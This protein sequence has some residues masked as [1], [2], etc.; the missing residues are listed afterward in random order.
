[1]PSTPTRKPAAVRTQP[2][3]GIVSASHWGVFRG[4]VE[5]G[6]VVA[7]NPFERDSFP[8]P[9][10]PGI[11]DVAHSPTRIRAPVVRAGY[12]EHG[13]G[14]DRSRR[15]A[16][17]FVRVSWDEALDLVTRD[18][19]RVLDL[20]GGSAVFAGSYGWKSTGK[21]HMP[22]PLLKRWLNLFNKGYVDSL[23]SYSTAGI[24]A[25][26]PYVTGTGEI[27]E[28]QTSWSVIA[29]HSDVVVL[30]GA[31][32]LITNQIGWT[33]PD[34]F[35]YAG[36][37]LLKAANKRVIV[38]DPVR[39]PCVDYFQAEWIGVRP[40]T[41]V[42]LMLGIAHT[43]VAE[44]LYDKE[45]L[46]RCT[47]GFERFLPYLTGESDGT[48]KSADWAAGICDL[49]AE[50]IRSLARLFASRRT[51]LLAGWAMQRQHH[52]E[53]PHWMLVTLS[54]MLGH[55]GLPG[56]GFGFTHHYGG[57]G[58]SR[59]RSPVLPGLP[60][61][62][63][64]ARR[65]WPQS[66]GSPAI[67]VAR[68]VDM[69]EHP[70]KTIDYDGKKIVYPDVRFIYWAGGNPLSHH[71]DRNR[72]LRAW[73][74]VE[75]F[76]VQDIQW[77]AT[78]RHADIVLPAATALER[79]DIEQWGNGVYLRGIV[80]QKKMMEPL[81]DSKTDYDIFRLLAARIGREQDFTE[82]RDALGWARALY[83]S[84]RARAAADGVDMPTFEEFWDRGHVEFEPLPE[85]LDYVR[86][87]GFRADPSGSPLPTPSGK[88]EIYSET[89]ARMGYADCPPHPMWLEPLER[90][91]SPADA[92]YPLHIVSK[93][94]VWRLHSQLSGTVLRQNYTVG[95]RAAIVLHPE[96]A[97]RRG[98]RS[99]DTVRVFN[100]RGAVLGGAVVAETV[101]RG[102]IV[103]DEGNWYDPAAPGTDG[104][105]CKFGDPNVLTPDIGTSGLGQGNCGHTGVVEVEKYLG[106]APPVTVFAPPAIR[107]RGEPPAV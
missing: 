48:P 85:S 6:R 33:V 89:I 22:Q 12:L 77:T 102:A 101:R 40:H 76:V 81:Y 13:P 104:T 39:T 103:C 64:S 63:D 27:D 79:D 25:I 106:E 32:L 30:W 4:A 19:R 70:G 42:A 91:G 73:R 96:D 94:M 55:I 16:E 83:D 90:A 88:F 23:G 97:A 57:V 100:A 11:L 21:V 53:Q 5:N 82:G 78:A 62:D 65:T 59:T 24:R 50:L 20:H 38:I 105:F 61:G 36:I 10:L 28:P 37:E 67:P 46:A 34:H 31:D 44:S 29:R 99:G 1:M 58:V 66:A 93:H 98:I 68:I 60:K 35:C 87:A 80:A 2:G 9:C 3:E 43:L 56:G 49:P 52:G 14:S 69:L 86:Y 72:Q 41:D 95:G 75:T 7:L 17:E 51:M 74:K 18:I 84:S 107:E 54:A 47:T 92:A 26:M 8:S 71:Q 15:G 45:F